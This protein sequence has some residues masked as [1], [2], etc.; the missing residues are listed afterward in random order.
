LNLQQTALQETAVQQTVG[1]ET[2]HQSPPPEQGSSKSAAPARETGSP[3]GGDGGTDSEQVPKQPP[4]QLTLIQPLP[5]THPTHEPVSPDRQQAVAALVKFGVWRARAEQLVDKLGLSAE[6][7]QRACAALE[8]EMKQGTG[9][10]N[11]GAVIASRLDSGWEPPLEPP[12]NPYA[13]WGVEDKEMT[14]I[15]LPIDE[16]PPLPPVVTARG[17]EY[18]AYQWFADLKS[19]LQLQIVRETYDIWLRPAE[20]VD[21]VPTAGDT[22]TILTI[23]LH[24]LYAKACIEHRLHKVI[25]RQAVRMLGRA[26]RLVYVGPEEAT[27][28]EQTQPWWATVK[29]DTTKAETERSAS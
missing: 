18:N 6:T 17:T 29:P 2:E 16:R 3:A 7:V 20:L 23:R 15:G 10:T 22:P 1:Q 5:A 12:S 28:E 13:R 24:N 14:S 4:V 8:A 26:V 21:H 11:P 27:C 19:E 25:Q 9:I